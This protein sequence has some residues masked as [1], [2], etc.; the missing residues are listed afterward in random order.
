MTRVL[1]LGGSG[2]L[3]HKLWQHCAGRFDTWATFRAS[4]RAPIFDPDRSLTGVHADD[5]DSIREAVRSVRPDCVV[6]CIGIVK[7]D[8]AA[9]DPLRS[10]AVN[11]ALPH[12]VARF[13][14]E[15]DARLIHL[16]T[17]CVFSGDRGLYR[18]SDFADA[19]DLYGRTKFLGEVVDDPRCLTLRTSMIGRELAG[20]QGLLEWFLSRAGGA[21]GGYTRAIFSGLTTQAIARV[22]GDLVERGPDLRGLFHLA[23][24]PISKFDLLSMINEVF[25]CGIALERDDGVVCDRS[26]DGSRFAA[27]TGF[28]PAPW[29]EMI[30]DMRN[31]PTPYDL[32]RRGATS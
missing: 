2:M 17:D 30:E 11:A 10:L 19:H 6:N 7:Q 29:R 13:C 14:A 32:I 28:R 24:D 26:L 27:A 15:S 8:P 3:G 31:D 21:A 22:I 12:H 1:I 5:L 18:E 4:P 23:A 25:E 16:S 9:R 20:N